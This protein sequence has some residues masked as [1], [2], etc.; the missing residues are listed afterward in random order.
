M[1]DQIPIMMQNNEIIQ[2]VSVTHD[3]SMF[4]LKCIGWLTGDVYVCRILTE[5]IK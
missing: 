1:Y 5:Q 4:W 3:I 2:D